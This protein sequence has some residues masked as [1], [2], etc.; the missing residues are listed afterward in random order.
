MGRSC[1]FSVPKLHIMAMGLW[2]ADLHQPGEKGL[3]LWTHRFPLRFD[4]MSWLDLFGSGTA[5]V[6]LHIVGFWVIHFCIEMERSHVLCLLKGAHT[7]EN[8]SRNTSWS[9]PKLSLVHGG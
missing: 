8:K 6:L 1:S 5:T 7:N 2:L 4:Q 3:Q 9:V